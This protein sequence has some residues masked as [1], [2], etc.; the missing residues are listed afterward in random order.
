MEAPP[1]PTGA[2]SL[3]TKPSDLPYEPTEASENP[4]VVDILAA[5][6]SP[7]ARRSVAKRLREELGEA[8]DFWVKLSCHA[9]DSCEPDT[10]NAIVDAFQGIHSR[11][12]AG[13][14]LE[15]IDA[16]CR[17]VLTLLLKSS[18]AKSA[19]SESSLGLHLQP[20]ACVTATA[21]P[22]TTFNTQP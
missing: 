4:P 9:S 17:D 18:A 15:Q 2:S 20:A 10:S 7:V 6:S 22:S 13:Y 16:L 12:V 8:D 11:R 14:N 5:L 21:S 1:L 19:A 3:T